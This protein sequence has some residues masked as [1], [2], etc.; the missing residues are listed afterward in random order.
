MVG[1]TGD[2]SAIFTEDDEFRNGGS[3]QTITVRR[4]LRM[5]ERAKGGR[6][7]RYCTNCGTQATPGD[8]FCGNCG[9]RLSPGLEHES[10]TQE[11]PGPVR[12]RPGGYAL[13]RFLRFPE[14]GR[15]ALLGLALALACAAV[16]L[17]ALYA[18]LAI[19]GAF[20]GP[21]VPGTVVLAL[22]VL[23][24][25]GAASFDVPPIPSLFGLGGSLRLGL[26]VT[27]FAL[28]PF[29]ASLLG[30][31]FLAQRARTPV[32]FVLV[33][34]V[35]YAAV[36]AALAALGAASTD[37]GDVTIR[38]APDPVSNAL[39]GILWVGL[40]TMLGAA[41]SRGPLLPARVRQVLRGALWAVGISLAVALVLAVIVA[42]TQ[43]G[44]GA[45]GPVQGAP[46]GLPQPELGS[47]SAGG[48]LAVIGAVFALL[49]VGLGNLWLL[50]HGV[51]VGF[52]NAPDLSGIP[53]VGE[54]LADVPLRVAL[55]GDWPW[56]AAWRLLLVG[57]VVGLVFGGLVAA[58]GAPP[59]ARWQQGALVA[60]PY[61]AVAL[62][63]A[64]LLGA[65]ADLSLAGAT[66]LRV[67]FRASLGWLLL[68]VPAGAVLGAVGGCSP[69]ATPSRSRA[70]TAP[71]SPPR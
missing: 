24:H 64:V 43:Q 58:R 62:L 44:S 51:P 8:V 32:L 42:M 41:A 61:A 54:A 45:P 52:Q 46:E 38:F 11:L 56:G 9:A 59:G 37:S 19:R 25:G 36:V 33:T 55:L 12:E 35:A 68:L 31:R 5:G 10:P 20:S 30:A 7:R 3:K 16:L 40:G 26:P 15:D 2:P 47:S 71:S 23:L 1:E 67:A 66:N 6:P 53:L 34:A 57:P 60:L 39:R 65:T 50:A 13:P 17:A 70:P 29:L 14:P 21:S 48:A 22:F 63:A 4:G 18:L 27:S 69:G 28:L 49:P